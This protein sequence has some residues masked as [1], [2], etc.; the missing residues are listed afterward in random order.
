MKGKSQQLEVLSNLIKELEPKAEMGI[1][2]LSSFSHE[3][4]NC[5]NSIKEGISLISQGIIGKINQK[6]AKALKLTQNNIDRLVRLS[7]EFL[8]FSKIGSG[9]LQ[10]NRRLVDLAALAQQAQDLFKFTARK[11]RIKMELVAAKTLDK[12]WADPDRLS[13]VFTNLFNNAVK[14]TPAGGKISAQLKDEDNQIRVTVADTGIGIYESD[15]KKIFARF[16]QANVGGQQLKQKG[17]GLGLAIVKEII[18]MHK[19]RIRV[20]SKPGKGTK[21]I[22][23]LPKDVRAQQ[24][25]MEP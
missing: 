8:D 1:D 20:E 7:N 22:F 14:F 2:M 6:Q 11:S 17:S 21:F 13:Q 23:N 16:Q 10:L 9:H 15:Q 18:Q 25:Q 19:G 24:R 12:I 4:C 3:M 5:L